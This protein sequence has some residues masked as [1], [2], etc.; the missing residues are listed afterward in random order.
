MKT[1]GVMDGPYYIKASMNK[2]YSNTRLL[3]NSSTMSGITTGYYFCDVY[4]CYATVKLPDN[5]LKVAINNPT[6]SGY[7]DLNSLTIGVNFTMTTTGA[8][9]FI[10]MTTYTIVINY[11]LLGQSI[12][13]EYPKD[14]NSLNFSCSIMA[15]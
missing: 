8:G 7:S 1:I 15:Y 3:I 4:Y 6:Q 9:T 14:R 11:N 12:G 5:Y 2:F 10:Y 13:N